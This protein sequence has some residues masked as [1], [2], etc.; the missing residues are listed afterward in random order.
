MPNLQLHGRTFWVD[1][2]ARDYA[3]RLSSHDLILV[4]DVRFEDEWAVLRDVTSRAGPPA[5]LW[6]V[7]RPGVSDAETSPAQHASEQFHHTIHTQAMFSVQ[8]L[9]NGTVEELET[10][11]SAALQSLL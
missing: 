7:F 3:K 5:I 6:H 4:T 1:V 10:R 2:F 9:N 8:T 11:V